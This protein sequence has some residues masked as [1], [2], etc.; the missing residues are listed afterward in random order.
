MKLEYV[1]PE[2]IEKRS[3][4]IISGE[5]SERGVTLEPKQ[6]PIIMRVIHTTADFDYLDNLKFSE[7]AV[8]TALNALREGAYIIT[9]TNMALSGINKAALGKLG[10]EAYCFMADSDVAQAAKDKGVTRACASVE[11][12]SRLGGKP[13]ILVS[14]NAPTFLIR[15]REL[16]D[17]GGLA[18]ALVIAMPV[19]FVNVVQSKELI[20]S[21]GAEYIAARGRKGGSNAAAAVVNALMYML[22]R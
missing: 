19:G 16:M 10:C 14:G 20:M 1:R 7:N 9:D 15:A 12:A 17:S 13:L 4:E 6:A 2:D 8:D 22:T 3:F 18:P 21:S 5:I 11:K